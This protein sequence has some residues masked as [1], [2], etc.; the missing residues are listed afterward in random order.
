MVGAA[1]LVEGIVKRLL[2]LDHVVERARVHGIWHERLQCRTPTVALTPC[3]NCRRKYWAL[4]EYDGFAV[5]WICNGCRDP[6]MITAH[7]LVAP[8]QEPL[9]LDVLEEAL[10][11]AEQRVDMLAGMVLRLVVEL[12]RSDDRAKGVTV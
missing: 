10:E 11:E 12:G 1:L 6:L 9:L 5:V 7:L 8:G 3:P 2:D 4:A